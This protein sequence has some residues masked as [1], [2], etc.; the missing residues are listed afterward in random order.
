M[1]YALGTLIGLFIG[2]AIGSLVGALLVQLS[3][4]LIA[5]F[6]PPYVM[7]YKA[8]FLVSI[9]IILVNKIAFLVGAYGNTFG[10]IPVVV[11]FFVQSA[12]F[13]SLIKHPEKGA[14]GF[15]KGAFISLIMMIV[16]II[17]YMSVIILII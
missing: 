12:I 3:T 13:A 10:I 8:I 1:V 2:I 11:C 7:A 6:K 5:K 9:P 15:V 17:A 14:I 4:K 16:A